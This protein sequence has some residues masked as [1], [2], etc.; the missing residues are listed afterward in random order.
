MKATETL[1]KEHLQ[2]LVN[3]VLPFED[4]HMLYS[5][6]ASSFEK[7][8]DHL[9][10]LSSKTVTIRPRNLW[11]DSEALFLKLQ[12]R[13]AKRVRLHTRSRQDCKH[14]KQVSRA[15]LYKKHLHKARLDVLNA[16]IWL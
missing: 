10:P 5:D 15:L 1:W 8:R 14:F 13:R 7:L 4:L 3:A 11:C 12:K 16:E 6:L 2:N 9:E